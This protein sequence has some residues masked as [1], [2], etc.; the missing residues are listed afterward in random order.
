M[1]RWDYETTMNPDLE[2]EKPDASSEHQTS[3]IP[4]SLMDL[5]RSSKSGGDPYFR[6]VSPKRKIAKLST[7]PLQNPRRLDEEHRLMNLHHLAEAAAKDG[8]WHSA[9]MLYSRLLNAYPESWYYKFY[10]SIAWFHITIEPPEQRTRRLMDDMKDVFA[11]VSREYHDI[12]YMK[13]CCAS[14]IFLD[15]IQASVEVLSKASTDLVLHPSQIDRYVD[16]FASTYCSLEL[17]EFS[18]QILDDPCFTMEQSR[19][20]SLE[21]IGFFADASQFYKRFIP[22]LQNFIM[23]PEELEHELDQSSSQVSS[24]QESAG[25]FAGVSLSER[26]KMLEN[27][28]LAVTT[29]QN[30]IM[31]MNKMLE[32]IIER[33]RELEERILA[34]H[35]TFGA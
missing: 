10:Q 3:R 5:L 33:D 20:I 18:L 6:V 30:S 27:Q 31:D 9:C 12:P 14:L 35:I 15:V 19:A 22:F 2:E 24:A 26:E 13:T 8:G 28:R 23:D 11:L 16:L 34:S 1:S 7:I 17:M 29:V 4:N 25:K 32:E 21:I